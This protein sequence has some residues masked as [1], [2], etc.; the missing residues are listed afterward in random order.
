MPELSDSLQASIT[1][2]QLQHSK[3]VQAVRNYSGGSVTAATAE[4]RG[5]RAG[6][7]TSITE[8]RKFLLDMMKTFIPNDLPNMILDFGKNVYLTG[9]AGV[10]D[11]HTFD[12]TLSVKRDTPA[13][14][15]GEDGSLVTAG[16][17]EVRQA[18]DPITGARLGVLIEPESTNL[19]PDSSMADWEIYDDAVVSQVEGGGYRVTANGTSSAVLQGDYLSEHDG[20]SRYWRSVTV[21]VSD[22]KRYAVMVRTAHR[23]Y[24]QA[25]GRYHA[26]FSLDSA[27]EIYRGSLIEDLYP[28]RVDPMGDG[29]FRVHLY[30]NRTGT[31]IQAAHFTL[32]LVDIS[33]PSKV[34]FTPSAGAWL[35]AKHPQME[36]GVPTPTSYIPT[37]G[38][39]AT[40]AADRV[41]HSLTEGG[42]NQKAGTWLITVSAAHSEAVSGVGFDTLTLTG[43]GVLAYRYDQSAGEIFLNGR[44]AFSTAPLLSKAQE[45]N[46]GGGTG[47][48]YVKKVEYWPARLSDSE[49]VAKT[50]E[51]PVGEYLFDV[52]QSMVFDFLSQ[53]FGLRSPNDAL[54]A[55]RSA[56][57]KDFM[58]VSRLAPKWVRRSDGYTATI[59][60][61]E[62]AYD[63]HSLS[64]TPRGLLIEKESRNML[65]ES[66]DVS[67]ITNAQASIIRDNHV[68]YGLPWRGITV[69]MA[70]GGSSGIYMRSQGGVTAGDPVTFS[71]Y[72]ELLSPG[73]GSDPFLLHV[74]L[75]GTAIPYR[76][77]RFLLEGD[78]EVVEEWSGSIG[79]IERVASKVYRVSISAKAQSDGYTTAI[80]YNGSPGRT[81]ARVAVAQ[82]QMEISWYATSPIPTD[83]V[84]ETRAADLVTLSNYKDTYQD[85]GGTWLMKV[86]A[87]QLNAIGGVGLDGMQVRGSGTLVYRYD[88]SGGEVF[89]GGKQVHSIPPL[90]SRPAEVTLTGVTGRVQDIQYWPYR[91]DDEEAAALAEGD[92]EIDYPFT[93]GGTLSVDVSERAYAYRSQV[94]SLVA[95]RS[96]NIRDLVSVSRPAPATCVRGSTL[97]SVDAD[98]PRFSFTG[99]ERLLVERE[100]TNLV[101]NSELIRLGYNKDGLS[102]ADYTTGYSAP[103]SSDNAIRVTGGEAFHLG[104]GHT[105]NES[106]TRFSSSVFIKSIGTDGEFRI[107]FGVGDSSHGEA[108]NLEVKNGKITGTGPISQDSIEAFDDGW[109]RVSREVVTDFTNYFSSIV[110]HSIYEGCD[111][112]IWGYQTET[113]GLTSYIPTNGFTVTRPADEVRYEPVHGMYSRTSG[114]WTITGRA[115]QGNLCLGL[116]FDGAKLTGIGTVV[117][118][119]DESGGSL[120]AGGEKLFDTPP[121]SAMPPHMLFGDVEGVNELESVK[122]QFGRLPESECL[123]LTEAGSFELEYALKD[124]ESL[125]MLFDEGICAVRDKSDALEVLNSTND[126]DIFTCR[127]MSGGL[128]FT[129]PKS[130]TF[131]GPDTLRYVY[132]EDE[133]RSLL[134]EHTSTNQ[135][136]Y[137]ND[138]SEWDES[139][140]AHDRYSATPFIDNL[141]AT[142]LTNQGKTEYNSIV[143]PRDNLTDGPAV[144]SVYAERGS[145][146]VTRIG[147]RDDGL[148]KWVVSAIYNWDTNKITIIDN[149]EGSNAS[150]G[151]DYLGYPGPNRGR[152]VRIWVSALPKNVGNASRVYIYPTGTSQ[153]TDYI[154]LHGTQAEDASVPSS[155][156]YTDGVS[157]TRNADEVYR[158]V[159]EEYN[160]EEGTFVLDYNWYGEFENDNNALILS[161]VPDQRF[162]YNPRKIQAWDGGRAVS[163]LSSIAAGTRTRVAMSYSSITNKLAIAHNGEKFTS[164][165]E[166]SGGYSDLS[167]LH[168]MSVEHAG[169]QIHGSVSE[170]RYYPFAHSNDEL[171]A[172]STMEE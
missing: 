147:I 51:S 52:G 121:L 79:R 8:N 111:L 109:Y 150:A 54:I 170:L 124:S 7:E 55:E 44:R 96:S 99:T 1:D 62:P 18:H 156:I 33:E 2:L 59:P 69:V 114:T 60:P 152:L 76:R 141:P 104:T 47:V 87:E 166:Y 37:S 122:Y 112:L 28:S 134:L 12:D 138:F 159:G 113:G 102:V 98:E 128:S 74:G 81:G 127:R 140:G 31:N 26:T 32:A 171:L 48:A 68:L 157:A 153:N 50:A 110:F 53:D 3:L 23:N 19:I 43:A 36:K 94:D 137:S 63:H 15:I 16:V 20:I 125:A 45:L 72:V 162:F 57:I 73:A 25:D 66:E 100:S 119:Y 160:S 17:D 136:A 4:L 56:D 161:G 42:F 84:E 41:T 85:V 61:D 29:W 132:D 149:S 89:V 40:R 151:V 34:E 35:E 77:A 6:V 108:V 143:T 116:G 38:S 10:E 155:L 165:S 70:D 97:T 164:N 135:I 92:L 93:S 145:A 22:P 142:R 172:L 91:I 9:I 13:T 158:D 71:A 144:F 49:L 131:V 46:L 133:R 148:Q 169:T 88:L 105:F 78:G 58:S 90:G 86:D 103:D 130:A 14:Y 146:A 5:A 67:A 154:Y 101:K 168:V 163:N 83:G 120:Y 115:R 129:S 95:G 27:A 139:S 80:I 167:R 107:L 82:P 118:A 64:N 117:F 75:E 126:H 11:S 65:R 123:T 30:G 21:R 39:P 106:G 24:Y